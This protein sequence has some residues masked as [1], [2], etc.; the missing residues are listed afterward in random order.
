[1]INRSI[2]F[3]CGFIIG[4]LIFYTIA[5]IFN[6][7]KDK[8]GTY[9]RVLV[10]KN[11]KFVDATPDEVQAALARYND[12]IKLS[13]IFSSQ[14]AKEVPMMVEDY[15]LLPYHRVIE[16]EHDESGDY[17]V[18]KVTEFDGCQST[19]NTREEADHNLTKAMA[20]WIEAK[21][22]SGF[23]VPMPNADQ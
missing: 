15:L 11:G 23:E 7:S 3:A 14:I 9:A 22:A 17:F 10:K 12:E 21:L 1:M 13:D 8:D 2:I 16:E 19:G 5:R 4:C 18:A 6:K 20:G